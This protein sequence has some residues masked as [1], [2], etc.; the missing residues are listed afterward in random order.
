MF[1]LVMM[2][3]RVEVRLRSMSLLSSIWPVLEYSFLLL[4]GY[5]RG[6]PA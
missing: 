3:A 4:Y 1:K 6:L 5:S 2:L